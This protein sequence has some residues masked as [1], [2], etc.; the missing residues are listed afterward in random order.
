MMKTQPKIMFMAS[1]NIKLHFYVLGER[2]EALK[3][4]TGEMAKEEDN[5]LLRHGP[6]RKSYQD[7]ADL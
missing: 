5:M 7:G 3:V 6:V 2:T 4:L 1:Y